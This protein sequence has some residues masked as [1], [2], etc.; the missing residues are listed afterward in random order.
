MFK[1]Y[2]QTEKRKLY[3]SE[4]SDF[5]G[6]IGMNLLTE[7]DEPLELMPDFDSESESPTKV[8]VMTHSADT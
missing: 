2:D 3:F 7:K 4:Y 6:C 1:R 8:K 5:L